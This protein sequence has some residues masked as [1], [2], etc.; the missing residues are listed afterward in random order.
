MDLTSE[1]YEFIHMYCLPESKEKVTSSIKLKK[2]CGFTWRNLT[3]NLKEGVFTIESKFLE[4]IPYYT[5]S[6]DTPSLAN[7]MKV[8]LEVK[9]LKVSL[10]TV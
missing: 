8:S 3:K 1:E 4:S 9:Q 6:L 5:T 10:K 2:K 7:S